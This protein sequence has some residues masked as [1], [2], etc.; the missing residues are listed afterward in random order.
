MLSIIIFSSPLA[1]WLSPNL[2]ALSCALLPTVISLD[3][4]AH[5]F[6]NTPTNTLHSLSTAKS[7]QNSNPR[8]AQLFTQRWARN[9]P[10]M[11]G[12]CHTPEGIGA[13][14]W[15]RAEGSEGPQRCAAPA[16]PLTRHRSFSKS[17]LLF[18]LLTIYPHSQQI[19]P[20]PTS[21]KNR[22]WH[23]KTWSHNQRYKLPASSPNCPSTSGQHLQP[24][25]FGSNLS[26][27]LGNLLLPMILYSLQLDLSIG[28][29]LAQVLSRNKKQQIHHLFFNLTV[30]TLALSPPT[31]TPFKDKILERCIHTIIISHLSW[32]LPHSIIVPTFITP[33]K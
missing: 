31:P 1:S 24:V 32:S 21:Q 13:G 14:E 26:G 30:F 16:D 11:V 20:H 5:H 9:N 7:W 12:K 10:S 28:F 15:E 23:T 29:K 18:K 4:W 25:H 8:T 6:S 3:P 17:S 22:S 27:C 19:T 33:L 2:L